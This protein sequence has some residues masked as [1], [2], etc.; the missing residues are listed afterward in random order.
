MTAD[1]QPVAAG[2]QDVQEYE[3]GDV[4]ARQVFGLHAVDAG[5]Q[6]DVV[7]VQDATE[8]GVNGGVVKHGLQFVSPLFIGGAEIIF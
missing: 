2:H 3:V 7:S 1:V 8:D 6:A 4:L 5:E